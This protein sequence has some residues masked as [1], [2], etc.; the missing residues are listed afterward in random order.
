MDWAAAVPNV[1]PYEPLLTPWVKVAL[2]VVA[3]GGAEASIYATTD[4]R[5]GTGT[6]RSNSIGL[7][8]Y[9]G[10]RDATSG[11]AF[12]GL[13]RH[14]VSGIGAWALATPEKSARVANAVAPK[15]N[16]LISFT[17]S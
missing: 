1:W 7:N 11:K 3:A 12:A 5:A 10:S 13:H 17:P 6:K 8:W 9:A 16:F 15:S 14:A 2:P 4:A